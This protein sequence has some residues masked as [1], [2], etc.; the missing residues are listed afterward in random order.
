MQ[1]KS[2]IVK[3]AIIIS[4]VSAL[5]AMINFLLLPLFTKY[6]E[7]SSYGYFSLL[8]NVSVFFSIVSGLNMASAIAAFYKSYKDEASLKQFI[9]NALVFSF[10]VNSVILCICSLAGDFIANII[11]EEKISY[12]PD[13][14]L[15]IAIG[16]FSNIFLIYSYYLRYDKQVKRFSM[17]AVL[18]VLLLAG[19]QVFYLVVLRSGV[20][21][22]LI[23]RL[24]AAMA[25]LLLIIIVHRQFL[26]KP[27][28]YNLN[29]KK[30]LKYSL[31]TGPALLIG[32][33]TTYGDRFMLERFLDGPNDFGKVGEYSFLATICSVIE[34]AIFALNSAL[35]PY[36]FDRYAVNRSYTFGYYRT[37]ILTCLLGIASLILLATNIDFV[38]K[39][40]QFLTTT[41]FVIPMMTGFAFATVSNLYALQITFSQKGSFYLYISIMGLLANVSLNYILI[42][43]NGIAGAVAANILTRLVVAITVVYFAQR[44]MKL[45]NLRETTLI[46]LVFL[47]IEYGAW[48]LAY[49]EILSF[50]GVALL[51]FAA[52][53]LTGVVIYRE[54]L[55]DNFRMLKLTR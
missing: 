1:G 2:Q 8:N 25:M 37:F 21:G 34:L 45:E 3:A 13:V 29:L 52:L 26:F 53:I 28:F 42:P 43:G 33:V 12:F 54:K 47:L 35:Q 36:I 19:L 16:L 31:L 44:A 40:D 20:T 38:V 7:T 41:P 6:F 5:P 27:L 15:A 46:I 4:I 48:S 55:I 50:K 18:Q 11:F 23:A 39:N 51:Q 14:F 49:F 9:G 17:I 24:L 30:P 32:W 22:V 10:I